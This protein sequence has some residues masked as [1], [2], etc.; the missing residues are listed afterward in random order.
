MAAHPLRVGHD[1]LEILLALVD[2]RD[3]QILQHGP[4]VLGVL[5]HDGDVAGQCQV[6]ANEYGSPYGQPDAH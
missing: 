3:G 6:V 2:G 1:L 4:D 5:P